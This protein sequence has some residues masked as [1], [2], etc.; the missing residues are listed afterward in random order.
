MKLTDIIQ[1]T[2]PWHRARLG[3]ITGT[4]AYDLMS[5]KITRNRLCAVI[6]RELMTAD[7]K[8][9][10]SKDL[11]RRSAME[12]EAASWYAIQYGVS[13]WGDDAYIES[14]L[15]PMFSC[16]PDGLV[17]P[18]GGLELK[19]LD[20]E[21]HLIVVMGGNFRDMKKYELQ[22]DWNMF[23]TGRHWWDLYFYCETLPASMRGHRIRRGRDPRVMQDL[24]DGANEV[25]ATVTA[26]LRE[27]GLS[28]LLE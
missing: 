26:F 20:E 1:R 9:F 4:R 10:S 28:G 5:S 23:V 22:C 25:L 15:H 14:D 17:D 13:V 3:S 7:T 27:H 18:D 16:S 8:T 2:E 24:E 19:R 6:V 11:D 21:N 12:T